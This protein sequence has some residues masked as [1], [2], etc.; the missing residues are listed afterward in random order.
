MN[1]TLEE[2]IISNALSIN[3]LGVSFDCMFMSFLTKAQQHLVIIKLIYSCLV[4][5]KTQ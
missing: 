2:S 3:T 5:S 1:D 4:T